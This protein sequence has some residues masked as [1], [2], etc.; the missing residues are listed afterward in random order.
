MKKRKKVIRNSRKNKNL[1]KKVNMFDQAMNNINVIITTRELFT[2]IYFLESVYQQRTE[3]LIT[4]PE[5]KANVIDL[6]HIKV[7]TTEVRK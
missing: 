1:N 6:N 4:I 7:Q 5:E 2:G 3:D